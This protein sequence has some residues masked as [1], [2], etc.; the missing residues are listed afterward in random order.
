[1]TKNKKNN[2]ARARSYSRNRALYSRGGHELKV[3][4]DGAY[5]LK[6]VVCVL[7]GTFWVKFSQPIVWS[8]L[9]FNAV[10]IGFIIGLLLV[11][12]FEGLQSNRKIWYVVLTLVAISSY[13]LPLGIVV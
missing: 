4:S 6:L 7:L 11:G 8:G 12:K 2:R 9:V 1:M 13:F 10:P 3:E 5:F